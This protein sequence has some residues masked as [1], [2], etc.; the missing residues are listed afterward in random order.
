MTV[1]VTCKREGWYCWWRCYMRLQTVTLISWLVNRRAGSITSGYL[2]H[3]FIRKALVPGQNGQHC[4]L[5][6]GG[7]GTSPVPGHCTNTYHTTGL[8]THDRVEKGRLKALCQVTIFTA[9]ITV[10]SPA[11]HWSWSSNGGEGGRSCALDDSVV[12]SS[13]FALHWSLFTVR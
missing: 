6:E 8:E 2:N 9:L 12:T 1:T 13:L 4:S 5:S 10:H 7:E 3:C 11:Q